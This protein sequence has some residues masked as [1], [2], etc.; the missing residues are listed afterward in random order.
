MGSLV[1][2][3]KS[4][5]E[6]PETIMYALEALLGITAVQKVPGGPALTNAGRGCSSIGFR[7]GR[8]V[9]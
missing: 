2:V 6:D 3:L 7:C 9:H 8:D 4:D 5:R 1:S